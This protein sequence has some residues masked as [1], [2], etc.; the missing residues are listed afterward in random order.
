[1]ATAKKI[2]E[3]KA[4]TILG[5]SGTNVH[6]GGIRSDE[7]IPE[8]K[9]HRAIKTF[10][11]MRENDATVGA[12]LY[13]VEQVL[14]DV[15]VKVK[16]ADESD[17]AKAEAE[18][19]ESV[20]SDMDHTL[21]DHISEALSVLTY[22]F[23][24]HEIVWKRRSGPNQK[25]PKKRSKYSD[26]RLGIRK[27]APRAPWTI[28]KFDVDKESGDVLGV[29][30]KSGYFGSDN[31]LPINKCLYYKMP[32]INGDPSGRS[33]LRN[34]YTSWYRLKE[35]QQFEAVWIER[36]LVGIPKAKI[37][38]DYLSP[39]RTEDQEAFV[40]ELQAVLRDLK[41]NSQ[42]TII[43]PSDVQ[44]D[45]EGKLSSIPL[46]DVE[47]MPSPGKKQIDVGPVITRY[48][49]EIARSIMA[50]FLMLGSSSTG[51]YALSKSKTDLFLRA[52]ESYIQ[53]IIDVLNKQLVERIWEMNNLDYNLMPTLEAGDVAPHDLKEL[54]SYLRNLNGADISL[55]D[56]THIVNALLENA[57]LPSIDE[58]VYAE[59]RER[60]HKAD[61]ARTDYYDGPDD[62]V[63]K[64]DKVEDEDD[65]EEV[66]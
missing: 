63:V 64:G 21:D 43:L 33:I 4:K 39:N 19:V 59:S 8:L 37:P 32:T 14:R 25:D 13:A 36:D 49:H 1:M 2:S 51:S 48:Q 34:A 46:V 12:V 6:N 22:G 66:D 30:Q 44:T 29:F 16:P 60:A 47:L 23:D 35:F 41:F 17:E 28:N 9:G 62:N 61:A 55:A 52:L 65:E 10:R 24:I 40:K 38:A 27:I 56:Q 15:K 5:V 20:L 26:G 11:Q 57:E 45:A 31:Y 50:E 18:F 54:G 53:Q 42:G 7:F 58:E 3:P